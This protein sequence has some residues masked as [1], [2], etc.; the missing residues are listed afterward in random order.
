METR[1]LGRSFGA[2]R[3]LDGFDVSLP[4]GQ[5]VGLVGPNGAGKTTLLLVLAG[6]LAPDRGGAA[7]GGC[8]PLTQPQEVHRIVGWMPDFFGVYDDLTLR[9]YLELFG[10]MFHLRRD[11][12]KTRTAELLELVGLAR[13]ADL[14]VHTL[15]RGQKQRLGFARALVHR[16]K[17]L[18]LDEP[19]SGLDPR[20]RIDLRDLVRRQADEGACVMVSSHILQELEEMADVIVFV[21]AGRCTGI[22]QIGELPTGGGARRW[23]LRA[24]DLGALQQAAYAVG[25][26]FEVMSDGSIVVEL[27]DERAVADLVT[28]LVAE[29]VAPTAIVPEGAGLEGAFLQLGAAER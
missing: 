17:V 13:K 15:S 25:T 2:V 1:N 18:L 16:P 21:E 28:R 22:Y 10:A 24:L 6:L 23:R 12:T 11:E 9:E 26:T 19:A 3:A 8:D 29:G 14:K 7:V 27:N 4:Y 5:V 20:A